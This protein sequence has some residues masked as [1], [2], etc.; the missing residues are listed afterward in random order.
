MGGD[1]DRDQEGVPSGID[2][3]EGVNH[4]SMGGTGVGVGGVRGEG[5]L[6]GA[7]RAR[8]EQQQQQVIP[9]YLSLYMHIITL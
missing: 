9:F 5:P 8:D 6:A 4:R 2:S 1:G 7:K 3:S